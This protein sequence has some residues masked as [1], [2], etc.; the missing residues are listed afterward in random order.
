[1]ADMKLQK[2][3]YTDDTQGMRVRIIFADDPNPDEARQ[4]VLIDL[5]VSIEGYRPFLDYQ[6]EALRN[7]RRVID[8]QMSVVQSLAG[9]RTS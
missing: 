9:R 8:E 5:P 6:A 3:E 1:M 7:A 4:T 2:T